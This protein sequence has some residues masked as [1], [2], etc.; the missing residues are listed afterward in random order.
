[1]SAYVA[2][3]YVLHGR[4]CTAVAANT[5]VRPTKITNGMMPNMSE[6]IR[7]V[8]AMPQMAFKTASVA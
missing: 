1:M 7:T 2:I 3:G 4:K 6:P 5:A 8:M